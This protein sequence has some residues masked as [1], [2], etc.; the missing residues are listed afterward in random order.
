[1]CMKKE[2]EDPI[3][4]KDLNK[5]RRSFLKSTA[6]GSVAV[7]AGSLVKT[8]EVEAHAYEPYPTDNQLE[9]VVTSCAH[10][11][12][13]RYVLIAHKKGDVIVRLLLMMVYSRKTVNMARTQKK[14]PSCVP[15]SKKVTP[16]LVMHGLEWWLRIYQSG[17][18]TGLQN[19]N[20]VFWLVW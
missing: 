2:P 3:V 17:P 19:Q 13:S 4:S 20:H 12:G 11:C 18:K 8:K 16:I 5:H 6:L 7:M 10:N 15:G 9:T 1:M 14:D